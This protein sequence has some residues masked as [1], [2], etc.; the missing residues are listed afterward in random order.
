MDIHAIGPEENQA[1]VRFLPWPQ[2]GSLEGLGVAACRASFASLDSAIGT[3]GLL[4][5]IPREKGIANFSL[6]V[7]LSW[8][9]PLEGR[10][11][12]GFAIERSPSVPDFLAYLAYLESSAALGAAARAGRDARAEGD[13]EDRIA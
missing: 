8:L 12:A 7:R 13:P 10:V 9:L 2:P 11:L 6:N 5:I 3:K 1:E 4:E